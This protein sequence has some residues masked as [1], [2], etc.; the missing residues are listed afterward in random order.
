MI[1]IILQYVVVLHLL[2]FCLLLKAELQTGTNYHRKAIFCLLVLR[3][4]CCGGFFVCLG[5]FCLVGVFFLWFF[6]F[7]LR[8][9]LFAVEEKLQM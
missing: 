4:I 9:L 3:H 1:Q 7:F 6:F 8:E 5:F 2:C